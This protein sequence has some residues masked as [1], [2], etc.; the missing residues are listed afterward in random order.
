M[1]F[2]DVIGMLF[3]VSVVMTPF[4]AYLIVEKYNWIGVVKLTVGAL[5][6]VL[7]SLLFIMVGFA[8]IFRNGGIC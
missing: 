8:I 4:I 3:F 2:L 1:S 6:A 5:I 7:I